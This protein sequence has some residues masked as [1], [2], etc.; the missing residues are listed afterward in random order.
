[1]AGPSHT[2]DVHF[3]ERSELLD[4]L[5]GVADAASETLDLD[6]LLGNIT[7]I[8]RDV[9]P[10]DLFAILLYNE[11]AQGLQIRHAIGHREEIVRSLVVPLGEGITGAAAATRQ[12]IVVDDVST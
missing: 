12:P 8:V 11:R 3:H 4:F 7:S 1:M 5:L 10:S 2:S 9:I 6:R